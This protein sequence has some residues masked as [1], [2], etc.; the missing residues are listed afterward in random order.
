MSQQL[1]PVSDIE[2]MAVAVAKSNLF[3]IKSPEQAMALMLIAQAEGLHPAIAARDYHVIQGKAALKS[4]AMLARFIAA[5]G[6]V[7]WHEYTDTAVTATFSHGSGGS[8]RIGWTIAQAKAAGLASKD[9]WK[10]YPRAM[11]RAR[12]ISEGI[13]TVYPGVCVGVYTPEEVQDFDVKPTI[14]DVKV[15]VSLPTPSV[16]T[17]KSEEAGSGEVILSG[18]NSTPSPEPVNSSQGKEYFIEQVKKSKWSKTDL[19]KYTTQVLGKATAAEC[20]LTDW[21]KLAHV[22]HHFETADEAFKSEA[23]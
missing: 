3:G 21:M 20:S 13:R 10:Q 12:V 7:E 18:E 4:D 16:A 14:R 9:V 8:V 5:G 2:R 22:T 11:L 15:E 1:V 17:I 6:K 23:K 19:L